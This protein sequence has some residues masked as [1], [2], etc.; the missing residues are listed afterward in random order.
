MR[1]ANRLKT[2]ATILKSYGLKPTFIESFGKIEKV[3]T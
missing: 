2:V 3:Y 1:D